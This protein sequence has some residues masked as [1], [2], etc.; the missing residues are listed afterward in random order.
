MS[1]GG[2][3]GIRAGRLGILLSI[4]TIEL[5]RGDNHTPGHFLRAIWPKHFAVSNFISKLFCASQELLGHCD[6]LCAAQLL[7]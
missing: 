5:Q 7:I 6:S 1:F 4:H 2:K 3:R